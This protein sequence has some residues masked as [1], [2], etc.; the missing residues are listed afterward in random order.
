MILPDKYNLWK[1]FLLAGLLFIGSC[2]LGRTQGVQVSKS[3]DSLITRLPAMMRSDENKARQMI[4]ELIQESERQQHR[5]GMIQGLFFRAWLSYRHD[6]AEEAIKRID[7]TL[8]HVKGVHSDTALV[9]FY[10][11]KG[12]CYVKKTQF[13]PALES[14]NQ[15][16]KIAERRKDHKSKTGTL[17]S[18][19]WAYMEDGKPN[20]AIRFFNEVLQLNPSDNY[21]SRAVLLCNIA[22]CYNTI[23]NFK[24]AEFFV[25]KGIAAAIRKESNMDLANGLNILARSYYQQGKMQKAISIL[26]KAAMAREKVADPSMLIS[27]YLELADLYSKNSQPSQAITWA[28]KAESLSEQQAN[29]LKLSAVYQTLSSAYEMVGDHENAFIYLKKLSLHKDSLADDHYNKAFAEMRVQYESQKKEAENLRLKKENLETKLQ[30]SIQQRWLLLLGAG[31][32]LLIASGVYVSKLMKSRYNTRLALEKFYEQKKRTMAVME[33]EEKERRR[34]A[35]DLHDGVGQTLAAASMQLA[36]ARKD[37]MCLDKVDDLIGQACTEV[38]TL[39]HQVTPELLLHYGLV[40]AIEQAVSRLNDAN[41][42]TVFTL[43]THIEGILED[44]MVALTLYRCF[45][46]LCTN[47]LKH[48]HASRVTVQLNQNREEIELIIEDDGIGFQP[49]EAKYGLG[50]KNIK[51]RLALYDGELLVDSTPGK[52][53]TTIVRL[54]KLALIQGYTKTKSA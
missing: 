28:K 18:I 38:R 16:L 2:Y 11:L 46:E 21:E 14:F 34:I 37:Q 5:H 53:T 47:I 25:Q 39:S 17:I 4:D 22:A 3:I 19:G 13:G 31:L 43:Y 36:K 12:Q 9:N 26:R 48:A 24:A 20:D 51:S 23:G 45:Q 44:E 8:K 1:G 35:A 50:L 6:P 7:S 52:G 10:I 54:H 29:N 32:I 27:D 40:K 49:K 41:D 30:N 15:A 33:A 42:R